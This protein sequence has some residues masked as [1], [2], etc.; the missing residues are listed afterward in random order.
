MQ[1]GDDVTHIVYLCIFKGDVEL[2]LKIDRSFILPTMN[3]DTSI[4]LSGTVQNLEISSTLSL[5]SNLDFYA[6]K[7]NSTLNL[8]FF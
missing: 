1:I 8:S 3:N 5:F 7:N 6:I 4:V 2:Y